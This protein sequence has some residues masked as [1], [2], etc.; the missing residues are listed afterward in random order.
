MRSCP[1]TQTG[2]GMQRERTAG[3]LS[4]QVQV[5]EVW[6]VEGNVCGMNPLRVSNLAAFQGLVGTSLAPV[7]RQSPDSPLLGPGS[8]EVLHLRQWR[9]SILTGNRALVPCALKRCRRAGKALP[10]PHPRCSALPERPSPLA[11]L[12]S[13]PRV[14]PRPLL[15]PRS[16]SAPFKEDSARRTR[17]RA[18]LD[19]L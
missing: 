6:S 17:P 16:L 18:H 8:S 7:Q 4:F 15:F 1:R 9:G 11:P 3:V 2:E 13:A 12:S 14:T 19:L 10:P 5:P